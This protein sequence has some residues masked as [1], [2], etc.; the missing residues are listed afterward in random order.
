M[1][2][3]KATAFRFGNVV[4][5]RQTHGVG[6]DFVRAL[7]RD[8]T[9]LHILG[10][11]KQSKSYVFVADVVDAVLGLSSTRE[12]PFEAFNIATGDYITV[13]E[14]A[15]IAVQELGLSPDSVSFTFSGGDRG[16]KGDVPIVRLSTVKARS[17]GWRC[18]YNCEEALRRS[19]RSMITDVDLGRF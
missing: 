11:G 14:I 7:R 8:P 16:W 18:S 12:T 3:L 15:V 17:R 1:F 2:D 9:Q 6:F 13:N 10:D 4:G 5:P 19:I